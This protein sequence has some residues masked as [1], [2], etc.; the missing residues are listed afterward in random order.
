MILRTIIF[1]LLLYFLIK[2]LSRFFLPSSDQGQSRGRSGTGFFYTNRS[3]PD[4][5]SRQNRG[6]VKQR[7]DQIEEAEYEEIKDEE[8]EEK[9]PKSK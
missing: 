6:S 4:S 3:G 5:S 9:N 1:F 2:V 8:K 7:L